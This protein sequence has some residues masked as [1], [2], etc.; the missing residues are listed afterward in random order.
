M[1]M[2]LGRRLVAGASLTLSIGVIGSILAASVVLQRGLPWYYAA[3]LALVP[4]AVRLPVP[5]RSTAG[6][7][8]AALFYALCVAG[9]ICALVWMR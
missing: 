7:A 5:Q 3:L 1:A 2:L 8:I 6:Q 4:L 9:G